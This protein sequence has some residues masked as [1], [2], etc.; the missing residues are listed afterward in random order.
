VLHAV[1]FGVGFG[2]QAEQGALVVAGAFAGQQRRSRSATPWW[3]VSLAADRCGSARRGWGPGGSP[4]PAAHTPARVLGRCGA[5]RDPRRRPHR[6]ATHAVA[7]AG[8]VA[9]TMVSGIPAAAHRPGSSSRTAARTAPGPSA[10]A[11]ASRH[12]SGNTATRAFPIRWRRA[13]QWLMQRTAVTYGSKG[14]KHRLEP[15]QSAEAGAA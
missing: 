15:K 6:R 14:S 13:A 8:L 12:S 9:N 11:D 5:A 7:S 4:R 1:E 10:D 3:A 2:V